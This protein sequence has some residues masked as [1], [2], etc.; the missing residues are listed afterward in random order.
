M[1]FNCKKQRLVNCQARLNGRRLTLTA[2]AGFTD[3]DDLWMT[4]SR[5]QP[6]CILLQKSIGNHDKEQRIG[7]GL[8]GLFYKGV[9][10][11]RAGRS[12]CL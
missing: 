7:L 8:I 10:P 3:V 6:I 9:A 1:T 2:N 12:P 4:S 5:T 11:D